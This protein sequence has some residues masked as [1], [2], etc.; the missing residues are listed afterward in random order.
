MKIQITIGENPDEVQDIFNKVI[1]DILLPNV[2]FDDLTVQDIENRI[3][4]LNRLKG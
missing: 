3:F 2:P 4:N 1:P